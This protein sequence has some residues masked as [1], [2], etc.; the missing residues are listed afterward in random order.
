MSTCRAP[1]EH[2]TGS[3]TTSLKSDRW[4]HPVSAPS[5]PSAWLAGCSGSFQSPRSLPLC[6][7]SCSPPSAAASSDKTA[8]AQGTKYQHK[9]G[10]YSVFPCVSSGGDTPPACRVRSRTPATAAACSQDRAASRGQQFLSSFKPQFDLC[11]K[12]RLYF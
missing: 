2:F 9:P 12:G 6:P 5:V 3:P 4:A 10:A 11:R 8:V 7:G 1:G